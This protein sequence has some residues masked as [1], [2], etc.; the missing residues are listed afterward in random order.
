MARTVSELRITMLKRWFFCPAVF[1]MVMLE[2]LG[3]LKDQGKAGKWLV[4][5]AMRFE[6]H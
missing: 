2:K 5:H 6:V 4:D 3:I 1:A